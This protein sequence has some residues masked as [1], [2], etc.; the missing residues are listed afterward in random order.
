VCQKINAKRE[1][2]AADDRAPISE[3]GAGRR[4]L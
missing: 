1:I 3:I 4:D 2:F